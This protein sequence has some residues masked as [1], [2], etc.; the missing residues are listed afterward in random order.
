M[1]KVLGPLGVAERGEAERRPVARPA[2]AGPGRSSACA[3]VG[4]CRSDGLRRF[5]ELELGRADFDRIAIDQAGFVDLLAVDE[6]AVAA[7]GVADPPFAVLADDDGMHAG[8]ERIGEDDVAVEAPADAVLLPL[9]EEELRSG[10]RA[11]RHDEIIEHAWHFRFR[12]G[13]KKGGSYRP[14]ET[15][16]RNHSSNII[17]RAW[18]WPQRVKWPWCVSPQALTLTLEAC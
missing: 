13:Q 18:C 9:V 8:G 14:A 5:V 4:R 16:R 15:T 7:F 2:T 11:G 12:S 6:R 17:G 1:S 10:T 3:R